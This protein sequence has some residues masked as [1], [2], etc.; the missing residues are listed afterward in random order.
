MI[1][2]AT[3]C[4]G[5]TFLLVTA[6]ATFGQVPAQDTATSEA[7]RRQAARITLREKLAAAAT[8]YQRHD[9]PTAAKTYDEAWGL[10]QQLGP[11]PGPESD[12]TI[13]GV[14]KVR[15]ELARDAQH[16]GDLRGADT[17]V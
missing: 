12:A 3:F 4:L 13:A 14:A 15:M 2:A 5:A 7:V 10:V 1:K 6:T 17:N 9:L 8:A 11:N 16:A